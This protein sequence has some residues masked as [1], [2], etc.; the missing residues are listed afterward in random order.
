MSACLLRGNGVRVV[1]E[2]RPVLVTVAKTPEGCL[3]VT[4][5][6]RQHFVR[7]H[8][9]RSGPQQ[10]QERPA[11]RQANRKSSGD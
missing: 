1:T 6:F 9:T 10:M 8:R 3:T 5:I 2:R 11:C 4:G 7:K